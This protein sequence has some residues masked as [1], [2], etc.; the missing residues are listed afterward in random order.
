MN[1]D[2]RRARRLTLALAAALLVSSAAAHATLVIGELVLTPDPPAPGAQVEVSRE[3]VARV[4]FL[5]RRAALVAFLPVLDVQQ[6]GERLAIVVEVVVGPVLQ[7]LRDDGDLLQVVERV[8]QLRVPDVD[9]H[10]EEMLLDTG[11]EGLSQ[12]S[13]RFFGVGDLPVKGRFKPLRMLGEDV[14]VTPGQPGSRQQAGK[15][16][17]GRKM[18][19]RNWPVVHRQGEAQKPGVTARV[20]EGGRSRHRFTTWAVRR[21]WP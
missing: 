4:R 12:A 5:K 20:G 13:E 1:R 7:P 16:G 14:V 9:H 18:R 6:Q 11:Q 8:V 3:V 2:P 17:A 15:L 19:S 10:R 21:A